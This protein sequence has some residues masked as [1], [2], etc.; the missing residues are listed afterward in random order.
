VAN[1]LKLRTLESTIQAH[2]GHWDQSCFANGEVNPNALTIG[3]CGATFCGAGFVAINEGFWPEYEVITRFGGRDVYEA[4]G[5]FFRPGIPLTAQWA[6]DIAQAALELN[7]E[8]AKALFYYFTNDF[9]EYK[10]R[11][12]EIIDGKWKGES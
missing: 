3:E 5:R 11:I 1:I 9:N 6:D 8:E 10:V 12:H 2:L 4:T 7:D